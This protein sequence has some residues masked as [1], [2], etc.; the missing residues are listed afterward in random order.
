MRWLLALLVAALAPLLAG[1]V[2][3]GHGYGHGHWRGGAR[4]TVG[5]AHVC[6][7]WCDHYYWH[8]SWY[9]A[10]H[11]HRPGCGHVLSGGVWIRIR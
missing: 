8:G 6:H 7:D 3:H 9:R 4:V 11:A 2:I 5:Y 10:G 1:C